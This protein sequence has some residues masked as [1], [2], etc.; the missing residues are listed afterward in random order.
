MT[1]QLGTQSDFPNTALRREGSVNTL[2]LRA[3]M[4]QQQRIE[5]G[6]RIRDLREASPHTNESIADHVGVGA[7]SVA[8]WISGTTGITYEHA[9]KVA[10]LFEVDVR[11]LWDGKERSNGSADL[12]GALSR[13][14]N[15]QLLEAVEELQGQVASLRSEL[16]AE[17][18]KLRTAQ[19]AQP[20]S[21]Q[22]SGREQ[23]KKRS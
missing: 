7:R 2:R 5:I 11:W 22:R 12:M 20:S 4:E 23:A 13:D 6:Q 19:E 9:R 10:E 16:L 21:G 17:L 1:M 18:S 14:Q 8:N 15:G 3:L